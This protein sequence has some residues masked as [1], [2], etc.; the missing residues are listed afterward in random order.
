MLAHL[1]TVDDSKPSPTCSSRNIIAG[2]LQA[3]HYL[4]SG[5]AQGELRYLQCNRW[6]N[7]LVENLLQLPSTERGQQSQIRRGGSMAAWRKVRPEMEEVHGR[8]PTFPITWLETH[9]SIVGHHVSKNT[10]IHAGVSDTVRCKS[11][12][13]MNSF[14]A[15]GLSSQRQ[16]QP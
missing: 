6:R 16:R 9:R 4:G 12:I 1:S 5:F 8:D 3:N 13:R 2:R 7:L 11:A 15:A 10:D 14:G